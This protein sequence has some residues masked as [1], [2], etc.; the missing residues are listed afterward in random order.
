MLS[1][2]AGGWAMA[3][4][5]SRGPDASAT[6]AGSSSVLDAVRDVPASLLF[7]HAERN[8]S[9]ALPKCDDRCR[10]IWGLGKYGDWDLKC[11][12]DDCKGC[13][14][15]T[16][17]NH[18]TP[19]DLCK[20]RHANAIQRFPSLEEDKQPQLR[21]D[22][23]LADNE[24]LPLLLFVHIGKTCGETVISSLAANAPK[25]KAGLDQ[26]GV[27]FKPFDMVHVHPVR[28]ETLAGVENVLISMR[29]PVDRLVSA[30][31]TA[32]CLADGVDPDICERRPPKQGSSFAMYPS[33]SPLT[34]PSPRQ[35]GLEP[36]FSR[37]NI[38]PNP[39][40]GPQPMVGGL[41]MQCYP[42]V[43]V[44]ADS[45]DDDTKCGRYA[46]DLIGAGDTDAGVGHVGKGDCFYL[47][48]VLDALEGKRIHLINTDHCTDDIADIPSWLGLTDKQG[49]LNV[50]EDA[51]ARHQ[52]DFPH[53][54]DEISDTGRE[55]LT[56]HLAHEYAL[57][58]EIR[59]LADE[60][61]SSPGEPRSGCAS[62]GASKFVSDKWCTANCAAGNCPPEMCICAGDA[63]KKKAAEK[64]AKDDERAAKESAEE[65]ARKAAQA[66]KDQTEAIDKA[67]KEQAALEKETEAA[68]AAAAKAEETA[69]EQ[70]AEEEE[71]RR[72]DEERNA[73]EDALRDAM[74]QVANAAQATFENDLQKLQDA[75]GKAR[76]V[77]VD[78]GLLN[79]AEDQKEQAV[80]V[81]AQ[82]M[83]DDEKEAA[84]REL[85][86]QAAAQEEYERKKSAAEGAL[87]EAMESG[88][89]AQI[90]AAIAVA[91]EAGVDA[92]VIGEAQRAKEQVD[93]Q[94][95][96]DQLDADA[97]KAK[98]MADKA[99]QDAAEA[100]QNAGVP[101][102][103]TA[104]QIATG[105]PPQ[106]EGA[107]GGNRGDDCWTACGKKA[108]KCFDK[109]TGKGY[110]GKAGEWSGSCCRLGAVGKL[111]ADTCG[112]GTSARGCSAHHC[113][114][115]DHK[116]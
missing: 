90:E 80:N 112:D 68:A 47:G 6:Y 84:D 110:C 86:E 76:E 51:P 101:M 91:R 42:N 34:S 75:I 45:I 39:A 93:L 49:E 114:V 53:H 71:Q 81:A 1:P 94:K 89:A 20:A 19:L 52:G 46:R 38:P 66:A 30:Y 88:D 13:A 25:I 21:G 36:Y 11:R 35:D 108:G 87:R 69:A 62:T 54:L 103:G 58:Q 5:V 59:K 100:A 8:Y 77:G 78:D 116:K 44:F 92:Q 63:E 56:R 107:Q 10:T 50:F 95:G 99:A 73:A 4:S 29:D 40:L 3:H 60:Q 26:V 98:E 14:E 7:A 22:N 12:K 61:K 15:C 109:E 48:G 18:L 33:P 17:S 24:D 102:T 65:E 64:K 67:A 82:M 83:V 41:V 43:T 72:K 115:E 85:A 104:P 57:Q 79:E 16:D 32:A 28:K 74:Q 105:R 23:S 2:I 96:K 55:R 106:P 27:S 113:C 9:A 37:L 111:T 70:R 97:E 31:N